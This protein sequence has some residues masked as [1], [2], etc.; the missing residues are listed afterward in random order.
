MKAVV[1]TSAVIWLNKI[2]RLELLTKL[3]GKLI[4]PPAVFDELRYPV[5][6][7]KFANRYIAKL[8][9]SDIEQKYEKLVGKY[10]SE[11]G[12][13][14]RADIEVFVTYRF[15]T[16][17]DE[18]LFANKGAKERLSRYGQVRELFELYEL[19]EKRGLFGR[20]D[21]IKFI[22]DLMKVNYRVPD[23]KILKRQLL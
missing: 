10:M 21:S 13:S 20:K 1:D 7:L 19:A 4:A 23:L 11:F 17:T 9:L 3:Y 14:D 6:V 8:D 15:F 5:E 22:N 12:W 18:M 2:N 16:K